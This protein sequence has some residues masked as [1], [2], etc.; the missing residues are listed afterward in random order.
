M[1]ELWG[2]STSC[3]VI[4]FPIKCVRILIYRKGIFFDKLIWI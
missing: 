3:E 4:P 2:L 1:K